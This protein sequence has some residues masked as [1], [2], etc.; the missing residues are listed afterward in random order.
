LNPFRRRARR[1]TVDPDVLLARHRELDWLSRDRGPRLFLSDWYCGNPF[2]DEYLPD[3]LFERPDD[4]RL[5]NYYFPNDSHE[6]HDLI[7]RFHAQR[8][9]VRRDHDEVFVGAGTSALLTA[10]IHMLLASG[11][12]QVHY[13]RPLY[14]S[15]Y[16][17]ARLLGLT[18]VPV[19]EGALND[20]G[21]P[22]RLPRERSV[23]LVC[24]P[25]WFMGRA[26]DADYLAE[27][28]D[29]QQRTGSTVLVDGAFQ[30]MQW[31]GPLQAERTASFDPALTWRT[32][33]PTKS[34]A[35]HG[36][37]F[38]YVLCPPGRRED[39]R[40]AYS[41]AMG[42]SSVTSAALARRTMEVLLSPESNGKLLAHI[43]E[44][45]EDLRTAG[46]FDDPAGADRTYFIFAKPN[47]DSEQV[48]GMH[49]EFFDVSGYP[50]H[51]RLNVLAPDVSSL[52]DHQDDLSANA[53]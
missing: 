7:V 10:Q 49:E 5:A 4:P 15:L 53:A 27:I 32:L 41:N 6:L 33:C 24:D 22:L 34:L 3:E 20:P 26:V 43:R 38:S 16:Y 40:Y 21:R 45:Y 19:N 36:L 30:Y 13:V 48:I 8:D 1:A 29:W 17:L 11:V 51:M 37:R 23:L 28:G 25:I 50:G 2:V 42:S 46:I 14:Y 31:R 35:L 39:L 44:Q 12:K 18:L 47:L 52:L 9:G